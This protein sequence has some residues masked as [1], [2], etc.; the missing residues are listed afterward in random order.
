MANTRC[1]DSYNASL[2]ASDLS[3]EKKQ[4]TIF[5]EMRKN[6]QQ[7]NTGNPVKNNGSNYN[8]ST[9][10]NSSCDISGGY[11]EFAESYVI[12]DNVSKGAALCIPPTS[13]H[14]PV[15]TIQT[16]LC[17]NLCSNTFGDGFQD[18]GN[19][20]GD[21]QNVVISGVTIVNSKLSVYDASA[22]ALLQ[23]LETNANKNSFTSTLTA[24]FYA[25]GSSGQSYDLGIGADRYRHATFL[26]SCDTTIY[27]DPLFVFQYSSN[28]TTWFSDGIEPDFFLIDLSNNQFCFQRSN[29]PTR[30]VRPYIVNDTSFNEF[31]I[32]LTKN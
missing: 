32:G 2:S 21:G 7:F 15:D 31:Q 16:T 4:K 5:N 18:T 11:V 1:F 20:A 25:A 10:I 3:R 22:N 9:K 23:K 26:G 19:E 28:N 6:V 8:K 17:S 29:V 12:L 24:G 14:T 13:I 30:Y 27:T